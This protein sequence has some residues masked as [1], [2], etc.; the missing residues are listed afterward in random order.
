MNTDGILAELESLDVILK[1]EGRRLLVRPL[2]AVSARLQQAMSRHREEL[3]DL[4]SWPTDGTPHSGGR[5][6][7][8]RAN[9]IVATPS[10]RGRVVAVLPEVVRVQL[11]ARA[12][13]DLDSFLA[14]ELRP[15]RGASKPPE[16]K[17][18]RSQT[19]GT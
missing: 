17:R 4:L 11:L 6:L 18:A 7:Q 5:P 1:V 3:L 16:R 14:C 12:K 15:I 9:S 10:G 19:N 13:G 2:T 8:H